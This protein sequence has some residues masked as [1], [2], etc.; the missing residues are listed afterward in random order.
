MLPV[1]CFQLFS[2]S[3]DAGAETKREREGK[4]RCRID[5]TCRLAGRTTFSFHFFSV[6]RTISFNNRT[7]FGLSGGKD[8]TS[9]PAILWSLD[10]SISLWTR[11]AR[12]ISW[13][14]SCQRYW[15]KTFALL[16]WS[17]RSSRTKKIFFFLRYFQISNQQQQRRWE[18]NR[19]IRTKLMEHQLRNLQINL[20]PG[21]YY[22]SNDFSNYIDSVHKALDS[23]K[24]SYHR[25]YIPY[26]YK[27]PES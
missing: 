13:D 19:E 1:C 27:R 23:S 20:W 10:T 6:R 5:L 2:S 24:E 15:P 12:P 11:R 22:P 17:M 9:D 18:T 26:D 3:V 25:D 7:F 14:D 8:K 16:N 21:M 4:K